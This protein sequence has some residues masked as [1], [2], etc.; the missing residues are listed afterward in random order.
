MADEVKV[1]KQLSTKE[2]EKYLEE[3]IKSI[4]NILRL[5]TTFYQ[6]GREIDYDVINAHN[7][8]LVSKQLSTKEVEK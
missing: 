4:N 3:K 6:R 7:L 2:V 1:S 5:E 8:Y